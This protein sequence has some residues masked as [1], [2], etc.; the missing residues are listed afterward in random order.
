MVVFA[1]D[2]AGNNAALTL[3]CTA[4]G[5]PSPNITWFRGGQPLGNGVA[6]A[7]GSLLSETITEGVDATQGGLL[8]P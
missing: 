6:M 5:D 8:Y 3:Q 7:D 4:T 2:A 1:L